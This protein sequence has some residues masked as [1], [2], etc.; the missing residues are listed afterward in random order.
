MIDPETWGRGDTARRSVRDVPAAVLEL[1][2]ARLGRRCC[3]TCWRA[4]R[5]VPPDEPLELDHR[6]PLARGGDNH[7]ANL[8]WLCRGCNRGRGAKDGDVS[9]PAWARGSGGR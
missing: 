2:D 1:V 4:G 6:R 8:R 5:T 7:H 9:E 3:E